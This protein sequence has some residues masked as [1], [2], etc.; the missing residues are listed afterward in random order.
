[1]ANVILLSLP[2]RAVYMSLVNSN[3]WAGCSGEDITKPVTVRDPTSISTDELVEFCCEHIP[4]LTDRTKKGGDLN[5]E[6]LS[7]MCK[8]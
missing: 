2:K 3:S 7:F 4:R 5:V 8:S 6:P 1:M